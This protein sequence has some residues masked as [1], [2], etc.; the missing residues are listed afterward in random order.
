ML[1][2]LSR[3]PKSMPVEMARRVSW[4]VVASTGAGTKRGA[5]EAS[6]ASGA[7]GSAS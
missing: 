2:R 3:P 7:S 4:G 6:D 1:H 5:S